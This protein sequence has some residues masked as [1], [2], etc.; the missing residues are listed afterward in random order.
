MRGWMIAVFLAVA[1]AQI[2]SAAYVVSPGGLYPPSEHP[3]VPSEVAFWELPLWVILL[4]V[5]I[6]PLELLWAAK[7]CLSLGCRRVG[8]E[9]VLESAARAGIYTMIRA[10][11]GIHLRALSERAAISMSTLR[12]HLAVLQEHHKITS[13]D[14]DGYLRFYE[15]SG[16]YTAA[17]QRVL[18]HLRNTTTREILIGILEHPGASRQEVADT[19]GISGPAVTWHMKKLTGDR[20]IRQER[21]GRAVRY[22]I[23]EDAAVDLATG[24]REAEDRR[25]LSHT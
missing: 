20:I 2:A 21:D 19:V 15:N 12:Y 11:P 5:C 16:T 9:N 7:T 4:E 17:Q 23:S 1:L 24:I 8:R 6:V 18:K 14:E 25:I 3:F 10:A 22:R 13:L